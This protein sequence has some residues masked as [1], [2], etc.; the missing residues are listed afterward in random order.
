[1][2][3]QIP[4]PI[5]E[6]QSSLLVEKRLRL[7]V[8][9]DDLIH[10]E[11]SGNKWRKLTLNLKAAKQEKQSTLLTFGGAFSNH[12][13]ATAAAGYRYG[14][15]TI[16]IIRGEPTYP[17]NPTLAL[18]QKYGMQLH[19]VDRQTYRTANRQVLA[20]QLVS[21]DHYFL[22]EGGTNTLAIEGCK[23]IVAEI[24][25]QLP[26]VPDYFCV[27]CGTGGTIGGI[28]EALE[29]KGKVLG[30]SALKGDFLLTE[31]EQ[32]LSDQ[33]D[34]WSI[35]TDFHF[36]GY[37]K[38]KPPLITFI[39]D[40]KRAFGIPLDP[41]YTAKLFYGIFQL[42]EKDFF[43]P[44]SSIIAIHT[45]GLQGIKGFNTRFGNLIETDE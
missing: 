44:E 7:W 40:F 34:N 33:Y 11:I 14:F 26:V 37:A 39:N 25:A 22:P 42:I 5:Q 21:S 18:T 9:R 41:I 35:R 36:E 24:K 19:Y 3:I 30:F 16:G 38:F 1:M 6:I 2:E 27:A 45:G 20:Q 12:I 31:V 8:K 29:G 4:S 17:L 23:S 15:Q 43:P 32:L 13:A 10:P 28:I